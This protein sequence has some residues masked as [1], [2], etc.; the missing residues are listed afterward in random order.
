MVP[1]TLRNEPYEVVID[2]NCNG[3]PSVQRERG[4]LFQRSGWFRVEGEPAKTSRGVFQV[5][6]GNAWRRW[7]RPGHVYVFIELKVP[8]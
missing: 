4:V 3:P 1:S 7:L 6:D 5:D 2:A 8:L